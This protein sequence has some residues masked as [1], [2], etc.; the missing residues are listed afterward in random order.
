MYTMSHITDP[1]QKLLFI[2]ETLVWDFICHIFKAICSFTQLH[3]IVPVECFQGIFICD[4]WP[5]RGCK[6][7][8]GWVSFFTIPTIV[9]FMSWH[10]RDA[11]L[12]CCS[13]NNLLLNWWWWWAYSPCL[14]KFKAGSTS[15]YEN[16]YREEKR[17]CDPVLD[18]WPK[19]SRLSPWNAPGKQYRI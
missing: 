3:W 6:E 1:N 2:N 4:L 9:C 17:W 15:W 13:K 19:Y 5:I 7:T 11:I 18:S 12:L 14:F 16:D 8:G 10:E